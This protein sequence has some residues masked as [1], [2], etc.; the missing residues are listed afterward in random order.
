MITLKIPFLQQAEGGMVASKDRTNELHQIFE[1]LKATDTSGGAISA[2]PTKQVSQFHTAAQEVSKQLL[3]TSYLLDNLTKL[4]S[5]RNVFDDHSHDVNQATIVI[6]EKI[7]N[8]KTQMGLLQQI[9][10]QGHGS[11]SSATQASE[12]NN[13]IVKNLR[14]HLVTTTNNFKEIL[15]SR[16]KKLSQVT[17]RRSAFTHEG[18]AAF[19]SSLFRNAEEEGDPMMGQQMVQRGGDVSYYRRRQEGVKM[20][21]KTVAE[22][23]DMFAEFNR[24]VAEQ[25]EMVFYFYYY[26]LCFSF[27]VI[28]NTNHKQVLRIDTNTEDALNSVVAAQGQLMT[29]LMNISGNR[30]LMMKIFGVLFAF[31][32]FFGL[33]VVN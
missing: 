31:V 4:I 25:E 26:Y 21:E 11:W 17:N 12:H 18:T 10:D 15:T 29:H 14:S 23:G 6:K 1:D 33:F 27:N 8:L 2:T 13:R 28:C 24:I 5:Q 22:L 7:Q 16:S 20:I 3:G 32:L 19:G 9:K 30:G